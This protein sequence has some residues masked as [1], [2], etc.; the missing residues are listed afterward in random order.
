MLGTKT[1]CKT[2]FRGS[3]PGYIYAQKVAKSRESLCR[4]ATG[5]KTPFDSIPSC[6]PST[7]AKL[8]DILNHKVTAGSAYRA[9]ATGLNDDGKQ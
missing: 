2:T 3:R 8:G 1:S 5:Q 4:P 6:G 7:H 9:V